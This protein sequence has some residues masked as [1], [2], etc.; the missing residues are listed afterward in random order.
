[1]GTKASSAP[2]RSRVVSPSGGGGG[3]ASPGDDFVFDEAALRAAFGADFQVDYVD[4][5]ALPPAAAAALQDGEAN[6]TAAAPPRPQ[7][8]S[9]LRP[10]S[11]R[12]RGG[13]GSGGG[14]RGASRPTTPA[15][16]GE[17]HSV[18]GGSQGGRPA[19]RSEEERVSASGGPLR[20]RGSQGSSVGGRTGSVPRVSTVKPDTEGPETEEEPVEP[21]VELPP[22]PAWQLSHADWQVCPTIRTT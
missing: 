14:S 21:V 13:D 11:S 10:A 12:R 7:S 15:T 22:R 16:G 18:L 6:A 1:M 3:G 5:E 4:T 19:R 20:P 9:G 17:Q 8:G 2:R